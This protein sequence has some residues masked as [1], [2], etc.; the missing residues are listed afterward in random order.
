MHIQHT[1]V[2]KIGFSLEDEMTMLMLLCI[3]EILKTQK[4]HFLC[5]FAVTHSPDED[6]I[7][8]MHWY[9]IGRSI[10][11]G[12]HLQLNEIKKF[13]SQICI[14]SKWWQLSNSFCSTST[15]KG[16]LG[17]NLPQICFFIVNSSILHCH[18]SPWLVLAHRHSYRHIPLLINLVWF[19]GSYLFRNL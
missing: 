3:L 8:Q 19:L 1:T 6:I 9:L 5:V 10:H 17:F 14:T 15:A 4:R 2:H 12:M 18:S 13:E 11:Y 7:V 16:K